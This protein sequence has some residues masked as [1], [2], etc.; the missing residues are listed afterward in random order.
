M[1][2]KTWVFTS[3][4]QCCRSSSSS[5]GSGG[6]SPLSGAHFFDAS[7]GSA[8]VRRPASTSS[9]SSSSSPSP[10]CPRCSFAA[11]GHTVS[12]AGDVVGADSG[13]HS[14]CS[15]GTRHW[16]STLFFPQLRFASRSLRRSVTSGRKA[17]LC[18]VKASSDNTTPLY[19]SFKRNRSF[20]SEDKQSEPTSA[21]NTVYIKTETPWNNSGGVYGSLRPAWQR[22]VYFI[23]RCSWN[24][25]SHSPSW[26]QRT[27]IGT[28]AVVWEPLYQSTGNLHCLSSHKS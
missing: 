10:L 17:P 12:T 9:S 18:D 3:S 8:A 4:G 13:L 26:S 23:H 21:V 19:L 16:N 14:P 24:T 1:A 2:V 22:G 7:G 15:A 6:N 20:S 25:L 28:L 27:T 11:L 5:S